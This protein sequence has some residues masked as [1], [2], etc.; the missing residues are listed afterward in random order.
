M[1]AK[2][3]YLLSVSETRRGAVS[4]VI[5]FNSTIETTAPPYME[6]QWSD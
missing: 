5:Q 1:A 4:Y 2:L 3:N 6:A